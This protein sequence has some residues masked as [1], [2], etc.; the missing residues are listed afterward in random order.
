[1]TARRLEGKV[2]LVTGAGSGIGRACALLFAQHGAVVACADVNELGAGITAD[3]AGGG[4]F[5]VALDVREAA[6]A[7]A[8]AGAVAAR[9]GGI[10]IVVNAAGIFE[11]DDSAPDVWQRTM[12]VNVDGVNN[13]TLAAWPHLEAR[14]GGSVIN[15]AS[16]AAL[17][18]SKLFSAYCTSKAAVHMLTRCHALKGARAGI[19]VNSI[20]P[21]FVDTPMLQAWFGKTRDPQAVQQSWTA[22][23]PLNRM[24]TADDIAQSAL[25][26][27]SSESSYM[28]GS[29]QLVDGGL[30][31]GIF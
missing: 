31:S 23:V 10:D 5:A 7:Q 11:D 13:V 16:T 8:C 26:L 29:A 3:A 30:L 25:F 12:A 27:A 20:C 14:G 24:A 2:A 17:T 22:T 4:A 15:L 6:S 21:G 1:M 9:A 19:R 28:T 18:G